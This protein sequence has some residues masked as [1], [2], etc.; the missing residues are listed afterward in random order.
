LN[1]WPVWAKFCGRRGAG[2]PEFRRVRD[3]SAYTSSAKKDAKRFVAGVRLCQRG[4]AS[5]WAGHSFF[6]DFTNQ[7]YRS[8]LAAVFK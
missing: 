8:R 1:A 5:I 2:I 4:S 6:Y 3:G 7:R